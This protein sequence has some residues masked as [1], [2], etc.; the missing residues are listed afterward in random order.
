ML[1]KGNMIKMGINQSYISWITFLFSISIVLISIT[2]MVFPALTTSSIGYSNILQELG[3]NQKIDSFETGAMAIPLVLINASVLGL[4]LLYFKN[5]IPNTISKVFVKLFQFEIS[6]R[7][8]FIL[9]IIIL[10]IYI[11]V[12]VV[13]L[14]T[15]EIWIDY[16]PIK[17]RLDE[18]IRD[19]RFT[20]E[21]AIS[22][23]QNYPIFEPHVKYTLLLIS[24]KIFGNY[25]VIVFLASIAL[26]LT[27]YF[28][29]IEIAKKRF[30]GIVAV[31]IVIQSNVFLTYDTSV[32][33]D[34]FWILFYMLSL[35]LIIR[36]WPTSP[37]F[38]LLSI[39]SKA[40]TAVFL[41]MT[42]FFIYRSKIQRKKKIILFGMYV[43]IG[44][45]GIISITSF[46]A[47]LPGTEMTQSSLGFWQGF[48]SMVFLLRFDVLVTL[49]LL[50]LVVGLFIASKKG[51]EYAD[52]VLVLIG[53][54]LLTAPF[55]T[56]FTN[57]TNQPYRFIPLVI[58]FAM[59]VGVLLS[60]TTS[61][62]V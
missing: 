27:V 45:I 38:Y 30:A 4:A 58:F 49:L 7:A 16:G 44:I 41:P 59:G 46:N 2:P 17:N 24:D 34:N 21:D 26:L 15:E 18:A 43:I 8:A 11:G 1:K 3:L 31:L 56:G 55:L 22:G 42:L 60:K 5:K 28:I 47:S 52:S 23:N 14:E 53:M 36:S 40:L 6:K 62:D 39:S 12:T 48:S 50:P 25:N 37:I 20:I 9:M 33:Y 32:T 29:T 51:Y 54:F 57:M 13:E 19:D 35:Y 10:G 61:E